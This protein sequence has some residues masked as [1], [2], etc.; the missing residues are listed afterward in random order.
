M[1]IEQFPN[2]GLVNCAL[3][4]RSLLCH[5]WKMNGSAH[6]LRPGGNPL[7]TIPPWEMR[8][9]SFYPNLLRFHRVLS[10]AWSETKPTCRGFGR[11]C[12]HRLCDATLMR[13]DSRSQYIHFKFHPVLTCFHKSLRP[14][15]WRIVHDEDRVLAI[16]RNGEVTGLY[17][18]I[19]GVSV[20]VY[21]YIYSIW[22]WIFSNACLFMPAILDNTS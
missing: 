1:W 2:Q 3:T 22:C 17:S 6:C 12:I 10:K 20:F 5:L 9:L 14:V 11:F 7:S 8:L 19:Y 13:D 18:R 4:L 15:K 16:F 21:I